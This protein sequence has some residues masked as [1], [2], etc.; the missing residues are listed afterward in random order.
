MRNIVL[1]LL[2][3]LFISCAQ[4]EGETPTEDIQGKSQDVW[5]IPFPCTTS[6]TNGQ[7]CNTPRN[8]L[9]ETRWNQPARVSTWPGS[10]AWGA[11]Q[12]F[13][14]IP[15]QHNRVIH[16]SWTIDST[17]RCYGSHCIYRICIYNAPAVTCK[18]TTEKTGTTGV[19]MD[20][21]LSPGYPL[22]WRVYF[23]SNLDQWNTFNASL[24]F[25]HDPVW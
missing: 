10:G 25:T 18:T 24:T 11:Y 5:Y 12:E 9:T 13:W 17:Q 23:E 15:E 6:Q 4:L 1:C 21:P 8:S 22:M 7:S 2:S 19:F 14:V 16:M 20:Q 3:S